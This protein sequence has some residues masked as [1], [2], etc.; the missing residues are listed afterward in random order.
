MK[1]SYNSIRTVLVFF[2]MLPQPHNKISN[3][4]LRV[5]YVKSVDQPVTRGDESGLIMTVDN[6]MEAR[7]PLTSEPTW[8][9]IQD[10]FNKNSTKLVLND[11]F[12]QDPNRFKQFR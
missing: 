2:Q 6:T 5:R 4:R 10:F 12:S 1:F 9:Q 11:L 3:V 8:Q 7:S